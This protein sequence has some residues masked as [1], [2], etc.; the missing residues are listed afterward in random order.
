MKERVTKIELLSTYTEENVTIRGFTGG[1]RRTR[2]MDG[3]ATQITGLESTS[4]DVTGGQVSYGGSNYTGLKL[5]DREI[6]ID[7]HPLRLSNNEIKNKVNSLIGLS[8][9]GPLRIRLHTQFEDGTESALTS[10]AYITAVDSPLLGGDTTV[11]LTIRCPTPHFER[12]VEITPEPPTVSQL[13]VRETAHDEI[14]RDYGI[15]GFMSERLS[16]LT[17]APSPFLLTI[18]I[19][20]D[21]K[22]HVMGVRALGVS[23]DAMGIDMAQLTGASGL[24]N[25]PGAMTVQMSSNR[26]TVDVWISPTSAASSSQYVLQ[27]DNGWPHAYPGF[28]HMGMEVRY[29]KQNL[30]GVTLPEDVDIEIE[31]MLIYP[32][33]F[34]V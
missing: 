31:E 1:L 2:D 3:R 20:A 13:G 4:M 11:K 29:R 26:R 6:T 16:R 10:E 27:V 32:R 22:T 8:T 17:T 5:T 19:P 18:N 14:T 28:D 30:G 7:V 15:T 12:D 23:G 24:H 33:S 34:G 25:S 9:L 21:L